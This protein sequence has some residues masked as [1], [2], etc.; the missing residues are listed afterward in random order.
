M[1][2]KTVL[3]AA[4]DVRRGAA[5]KAVVVAEQPSL[6][7]TVSRHVAHAISDRRIVYRFRNPKQRLSLP[8]EKAGIEHRFLRPPIAGNHPHGLD[9]AA[10]HG[11]RW[12]RI[13]PR[14]TSAWL[15]N[16]VAIIRAATA[17]P[18]DWFNC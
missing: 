8:D 18:G 14:S 17:R 1:R 2:M 16:V 9:T 12:Q 11:G 3:V 15:G 6:I 10:R 5:W 4:L 7:A 13:S